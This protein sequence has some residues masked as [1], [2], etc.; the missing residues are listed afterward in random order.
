MN[1]VFSSWGTAKMGNTVIHN[2]GAATKSSDAGKSFQDIFE[3]GFLYVARN[4]PPQKEKEQL[5]AKVHAVSAM[6][7]AYEYMK[8]NLETKTGIRAIESRG[9]YTANEAQ[10][11]VNPV[12]SKDDPVMEMAKFMGNFNNIPAYKALSEDKK[13]QFDS[14]LIRRVATGIIGGA[15]CHDIE[16]VG[17]DI[18]NMVN[19]ANKSGS[20][21]S[22]IAEF[23]K[24]AKVEGLSA[25]A[26]N[27]VMTLEV[28]I[29]ATHKVAKQI[30]LERY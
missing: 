13:A 11:E 14:A 20:L 2:K 18:E 27:Q 30:G 24:T 7:T 21:A 15:A 3:N 25:K 10:A 29:A 12:A 28:K 6:R 23:A 16:E 9:S 17:L 8:D 19:A 26:A 4:M 5:Y 1:Y 22:A